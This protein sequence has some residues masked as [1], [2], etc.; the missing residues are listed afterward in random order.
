LTGLGIEHIG[1]V[2]ALQLAEEIGSLEEPLALAPLE[3]AER[4]QGIAGF[5]P[6]M[7]ESVCQYL[8]ER[9]SRELLERLSALKVSRPRPKR[10]ALVGGALSSLSFCVTGVLSKKREDVHADIRNAGGTVHDKVKSGT[11]YLVA[12]EKVGKA[13]LAAAKKQ[14]AKVIDEAGLS[15]LLR[16]EKPEAP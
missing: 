16:G 2:A 10:A 1:Q 8:A 3:L 7:V 4:A 5:G 11:D 14:G 6:K 12:G 9:R 15:A 13:K